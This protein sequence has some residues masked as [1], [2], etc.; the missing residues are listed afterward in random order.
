MEPEKSTVYESEPL[1]QRIAPANVFA[2]VCQDCIQLLW[3]PFLPVFGQNHNRMK[4]SHCDGTSALGTDTFAI[5]DIRPAP[6]AMRPGRSDCQ[7]G[8]KPECAKPVKD[9]QETLPGPNLACRT[10]LGRFDLAHF[11]QA[12]GMRKAILQRRLDASV[13]LD[14]RQQADGRF[15]SPCCPDREQKHRQHDARPGRVACGSRPNGDRV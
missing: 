13:P 10:R 11:R 6:E 5:P 8:E 2:F 14:R 1:N 3:R 7:A 12:D 9:Q 15:R 4:P